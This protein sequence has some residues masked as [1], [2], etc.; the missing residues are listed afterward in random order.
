MAATMQTPRWIQRRNIEA[1][2]HFQALDTDVDNVEA[3]LQLNAAAEDK[4]HTELSKK[5][6]T[7]NARMFGV[8]VA[9]LTV[10]GGLVVNVIFHH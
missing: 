3:A 8:L 10:A 1:K 6:D 7:L 5:L 9:L 2:E 4:H